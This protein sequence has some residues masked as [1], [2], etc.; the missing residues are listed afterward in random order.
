[1]SGANSLE[2]PPRHHW[3]WLTQDWR[4]RLLAPPVAA[5]AEHAETW[6]SA[7]RPFIVASRAGGDDRHSVRLGLATPDKRRHAFHIGCQAIVRMAPPPALDGRLVK[8]AP[9][10]W[11]PVLRRVAEDGGRAGFL[12]SAFGSLAWTARSGVRFVREDSDADLLFQAAPSAAGRTFYR[13]L[14]ACA[15]HDLPR[16]DG[17]LILDD[18]QAVAW[19]EL[20]RRPDELIVKRA[21]TP[22]LVAR[23]AIE[24]ALGLA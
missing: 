6:R 13:F 17:E 22:R 3:V 8:I 16:L 5:A 11:A 10:D 20:A 19:R 24:H 4:G 21:G 1:M 14:E 18:G 2:P 7:G 15:E 9:I 23:A 12:I